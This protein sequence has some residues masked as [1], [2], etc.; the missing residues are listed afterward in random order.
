VWRVKLTATHH[1][2]PS[3]QAAYV[4][5]KSRGRGKLAISRTAVQ[6]VARRGVLFVF[7]STLG[8]LSLHTPNSTLTFK[9]RVCSNPPI[10]RKLKIS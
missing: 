3:S 1:H 8:T 9:V 5:L 10:W 2:G 7:N 4:A 6:Q